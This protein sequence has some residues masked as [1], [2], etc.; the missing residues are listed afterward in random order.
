MKS[1]RRGVCRTSSL[2]TEG[3]TAIIKENKKRDNTSNYRNVDGRLDAI[4]LHGEIYRIQLTVGDEGL[5]S[6]LLASLGSLRMSMDGWIEDGWQEDR[7]MPL[8]APFAYLAYLSTTPVNTLPQMPE[9]DCW[10]S[11]ECRKEERGF[12]FFTPAVLSYSLLFVLWR[13]VHGSRTVHI[14]AILYV[15][16]FFLCRWV[17]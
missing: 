5:S 9:I 12:L 17:G 11:K 10:R 1:K 13:A 8:V 3:K 15:H 2:P 14:S 7:S 16:S 6:L 4:G